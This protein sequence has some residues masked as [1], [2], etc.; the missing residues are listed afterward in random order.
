MPSCSIASDSFITIPDNEHQ[1]MIANNFALTT[2]SF[3]KA[4][5]SADIEQRRLAEMYVVGVIESTEG[6]SWCGYKTASPD[7]I[8]EQVYTALK[9]ALETSPKARAST[10]IKSHFKQLLPCK[11]EQ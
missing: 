5:M 6:E 3:F 7:A 10:V 1:R 2:E 9:K 4:Y 8:Q 11:D